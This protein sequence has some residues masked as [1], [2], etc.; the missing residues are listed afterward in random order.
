[1]K[2]V[3]KSFLIFLLIILI[4]IQF[5]RPEKNISA[6]ISA[7]DITT[8]FAVPDDV[9]K[10]LE[11]SCYDCHSNNTN[12]PWYSEVQPFAWWLDG[13]IK[14]GKRGLNFSEFETYRLRKQYKRFEDINEQ[15]KSG[16]M[17]L[18][19]YTL[20][21]R[22]AK[23]NNDQKLLIANWTIASMDQMKAKYPADSLLK[24]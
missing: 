10:I 12:Y 15:V 1:M 22:Y 17:P 6:T 7:N 18:S 9:K 5:F 13:H 21:H 3:I 20:I 16:E 11:T 14:D 4:I 23:L 19:S 24:R 8:K 2:K